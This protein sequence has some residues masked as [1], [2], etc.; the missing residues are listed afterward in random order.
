[1]FKRSDDG[2]LIHYVHGYG[3]G[4][5][6]FGGQICSSFD[7][8]VCEPDLCACSSEFAAGGFPN[9]AGCACD[10]GNFSV[11]AE[12]CFLHRHGL[13]RVAVK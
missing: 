8:D 6:Q 2:L 1:M 4:A 7:I 5:G 10:Q 13:F 11:Q 3:I 9:A 12:W